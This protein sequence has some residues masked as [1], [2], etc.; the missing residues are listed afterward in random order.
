MTCQI[1][2]AMK[3]RGVRKGDNVCIYMPVSPH[4]VA[5]ML[6]CTRIGAPHRQV[7]HHSEDT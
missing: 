1:A 4:A 5:S 3:T 7:I 2:N 6:A